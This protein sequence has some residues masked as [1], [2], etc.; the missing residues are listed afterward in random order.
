M[1]LMQLP[2]RLGRD[3][4]EELHR[5]AHVEGKSM[6]QLIREVLR[7]HFKAV[8]ISKKRLRDAVKKIVRDDA[9]ILES[10]KRM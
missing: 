6:N 4:Y 10:L 3:E 7:A 8:P 9:R 5:R 2:V 1:D